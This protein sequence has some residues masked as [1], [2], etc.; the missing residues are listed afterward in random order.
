VQNEPHR[1]ENRVAALEGGLGALRKDVTGLRDTLHSALLGTLDG[2]PGIVATLNNSLAASQANA[3]K[4]DSVS[5]EQKRQGEQLD[6]LRLDRAKVTGI[7]IAVS[8]LWA[9]FGTILGLVFRFWK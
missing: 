8:A 6:G 4:L 2:K 5:E 1:M 9:A 3:V 7:V